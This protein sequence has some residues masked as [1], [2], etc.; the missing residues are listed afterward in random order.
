PRRGRLPQR[1]RRL[2]LRPC[3]G[4]QGRQ[5][6]PAMRS[7]CRLGPAVLALLLI[8][9][10]WPQFLGPD[11]NGTS[12]EKGLLATWGEKGPPVVW[13]VEVGEGYSS[14]VVAGGRL[15]LFHR[16]GDDEVVSCLDAATGKELWKHTTPTSYR[17]PLGK[18]NGPRS[19][20]VVAGG[21]VY[22]LSP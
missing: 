11:R 21:K 17:D 9:A 6:G 1:R 15:V 19:T 4:P 8:G 20:P 12:P 2:P 16:V 10:D 7:F 13:Q 3:R 14:P 18:G 5:G 22:S